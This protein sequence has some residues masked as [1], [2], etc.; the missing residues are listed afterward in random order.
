MRSCNGYGNRSQ[1]VR[2]V[3][4]FQAFS[5]D[6]F[7][8]VSQVFPPEGSGMKTPSIGLHN[9]PLQTIAISLAY[10]LTAKLGFLLA[11]EQTN[12][13]AVWPPAGI[14]L[15]AALVYGFRIW[16]GIFLGAFVA[17]VTLLAGAHSSLVP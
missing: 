16:P 8:F 9:L 7:R 14:S 12:A 2:S 11:L 13:T 1:G 4:A 10:L 17:N 15:A 6:R 5:S 3:A